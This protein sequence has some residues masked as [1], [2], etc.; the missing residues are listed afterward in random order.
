VNNG[1]V[2][3]EMVYATIGGNYYNHVSDY[4]FAPFYGYPWYGQN[5]YPNYGQNNFSPWYNGYGSYG[6]PNYW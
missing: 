4:L 6:Y 1:E 5:N 2:K 3:K